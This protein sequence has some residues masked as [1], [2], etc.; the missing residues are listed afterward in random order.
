V[1]ALGHGSVHAVVGHDFGAFV[2]AWAALMRPDVFRALVLMSPFGGPPPLSATEPTSDIHADLAALERPRK[3]YQWYFS[4][5]EAA[6]DM[7]HPEQGLPAFLRA[8][9]HYKSADWPGNKPFPLS[10]WTARE[11]AKMPAYYVMDLNEDMAQ[12]VAHVMPTRDEIAANTWLPDDELAVYVDEFARTGFQGSLN[13]YRCLTSPESV[14]RLR[15]YAGRTIEVPSCFITGS[16]DWA[17]Y[18]R[19]G[20]DIRTMRDQVLTNMTGG[21]HLIDGAGHWVQQ[22]R[23]VDVI[24]PLLAFLRSQDRPAG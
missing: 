1:S 18:L 16:S 10:S 15:V 3:H 14:A 23:P 12:T 21:L 7:L 22:E 20:A 19:P 17:L 11:L 2:S 24:P 8:Y 4:T 6:A 13:W 9:Y 5:P